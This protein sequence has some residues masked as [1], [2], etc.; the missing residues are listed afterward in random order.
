MKQVNS[1]R[2]TANRN[3]C[4]SYDEESKSSFLL[5]YSKDISFRS[6]QS[7]KAMEKLRALS[8][9][10]YIPFEINSEKSDSFDRTKPRMGDHEF[11]TENEMDYVKKNEK[12]SEALSEKV[13]NSELILTGTIKFFLLI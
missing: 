7:S 1:P 9:S 12:L 11:P 10:T 6:N 4:F 5:A 8:N 13:E 3:H 2:S